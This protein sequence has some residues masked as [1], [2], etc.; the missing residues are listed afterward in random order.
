ME[1]TVKKGHPN[2]GV[3]MYTCNVY[4]RKMRQEKKMNESF[5]IVLPAQQGPEYKK[6]KKQE[7]GGGEGEKKKPN[8]LT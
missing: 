3:V 6:G 5:S 2:T 7:F 1:D 8:L 4:I